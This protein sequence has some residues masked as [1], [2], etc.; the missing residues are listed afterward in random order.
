MHI[1]KELFD[2]IC[3]K[4]RNGEL[5]SGDVSEI[6]QSIETNENY[7]QVYL[8]EF[9]NRIVE[10]NSYNGIKMAMVNQTVIKIGKSSNQIVFNTF[11]YGPGIGFYFNGATEFYAVGIGADRSGTGIKISGN[12]T[13]AI[14]NPMLATKPNGEWKNMNLG[15]NPAN[16]HYVETTNDFSGSVTINNA[17]NWNNETAEDGA[18]LNYTDVISSTNRLDDESFRLLLKLKIAK[19]T[20][21][22]TNK[23]IDD[24][25]NNIFGSLVYTTWG[26]QEVTYNYNNSVYNIIK[27]AQVKNCLLAPTGCNIILN[28]V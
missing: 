2:S 3:I 17:M 24:T 26:V 6:L 15:V 23:N 27:L 18:Y 19:N 5:I 9:L 1:T 16:C 21:V 11:T 28:E 14:I 25:I 22:N 7:A 12:S 10:N 4:L 13:G 20:L 8:I